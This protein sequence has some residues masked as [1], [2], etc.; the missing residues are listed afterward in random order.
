[1]QRFGPPDGRITQLAPQKSEYRFRDAKSRWIG[2]EFVCT[3]TGADQC[4][5]QIADH[6]GRW[7]DLNQPAQHSVGARVG[8]FDLFE[9]IS[10]TKSNCLLAQ[11]GQLA[12]R[13]LVVINPPRRPRQPRLERRIHFS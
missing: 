10:Q 5:R 1:M 7:R 3:D 12:A 13:N 11:I 6:L 9:S 2:G 4:Q 8:L